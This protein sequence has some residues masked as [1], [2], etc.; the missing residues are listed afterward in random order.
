[1]TIPGT[2]EI[3]QGK[4]FLADNE[5][6]NTLRVVTLAE[7]WLDGIY[8]DEDIYDQ[9]CDLF[10]YRRKKESTNENNRRSGEER[11]GR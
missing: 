1:M 6:R 7:G 5:F 2:D 11:Q 9:L 8:F 3:E 10:A 4:K